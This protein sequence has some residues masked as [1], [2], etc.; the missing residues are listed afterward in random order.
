MSNES[1]PQEPD[2]GRHGFLYLLNCYDIWGA[3]DVQGGCGPAAEDGQPAP[4]KESRS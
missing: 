4:P 2:P 3:T 1:Q